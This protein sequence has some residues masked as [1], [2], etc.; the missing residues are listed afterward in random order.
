MYAIPLIHSPQLT[1]KTSIVM[2]RF[3]FGE[4]FALNFACRY[5]IGREVSLH[6]ACHK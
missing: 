6:Q 1:I 2:E 5:F 4:R 3:G